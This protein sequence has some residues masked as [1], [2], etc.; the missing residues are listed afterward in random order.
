MERHGL[1]G[2]GIKHASGHGRGME[3][4]MMLSKAAQSRVPQEPG[5]SCK[6]LKEETVLVSKVRRNCPCLVLN[7][8][9][10]G[11]RACFFFFPFLLLFF[12]VLSLP[13]DTFTS[14]FEPLDACD[15]S[16]LFRAASS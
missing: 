13:R 11:A 7:I 8:C 4:S 1:A 14:D 3:I 6:P 12:H 9:W 10:C 15:P 2:R 5:R 16:V